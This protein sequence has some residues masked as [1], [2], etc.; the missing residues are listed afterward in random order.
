MPSDKRPVLVTG[1][2]GTTGRAVVRA[3]GDA[4][5]PLRAQVRSRDTAADLPASV[6]IA[7]GDFAEPISLAA[8]CKG[9]RS[10]FM[11]S[12][13][14]ADQLALQ[15]NLIEACRAAGVGMVVRLSA[16]SAAHDAPSRLIRAHAAADEQ[17]ARSG[18]G[19]CLLKPSWFHQ[20][21]LI[22]CPGGKLRLPVGDGR[23]PFI[24]VR[25]IAAVAVRALTEPGHVGKSYLLNGPELLSHSDVARILSEAT[26]RRFVFEDIAPE[27]W[28][29]EAI[30][31]GM[32][33]DAAGQV[34]DILANIKEGKSAIEGGDVEHV[35]GRKPTGLAA[36]ARDHAAALVKQL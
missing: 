4:G 23:V 11:A 35:L 22:Y 36:F 34:L 31:S 3:I 14:H 32:T 13:D 8:A 25:D 5:I 12:F 27:S 19:Y 1:A 29:Q 17:L 15:N 18:L 10:V 33:E 24:D 7:I 20:N 30:A 21:F 6:E 26:G 16:S 28:Q 9:V 2:N